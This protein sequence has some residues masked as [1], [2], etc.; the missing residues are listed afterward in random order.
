[1]SERIY[2]VVLERNV[3]RSK[4]RRA[5]AFVGAAL[6]YAGLGIVVAWWDPS[7]ESWASEIAAHVHSELDRTAPVAI[8]MPDPPKPPPPPTPAPTPPPAVAA[9]PKGAASPRPSPRAA[10]EPA[11]AGKVLAADPSAPA[12]FTSTP[13]VTG[14]GSRYVGGTTTATGTSTTP[15]PSPPAAA[16]VE[17]QARPVGKRDSEWR[18]PWP[19]EAESLEID[20]QSATIRVRVSATGEAI[21]VKSVDDPGYGFG[22]AARACAMQTRWEP[23][24]DDDGTPVER[25]S[26]PVRVRFERR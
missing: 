18:C 20:Q 3:G 26:P 23:A 10:S 16:P 24:L 17:S 19:S 21:D 14:E 12:D 9:P 25:W 1:M 2:D 4:Q 7:L 5:V 11:Q 22:R 13:I 8:E 6:L 15:A